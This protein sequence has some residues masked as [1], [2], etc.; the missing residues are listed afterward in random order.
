MIK[1]DLS[2]IDKA[3]KKARK[4]KLPDVSEYCFTPVPAPRM[5]RA[6]GWRTPKR[7]CVQR[8]FDFKDKVERAAVQ[9]PESGAHITF[10]MPMPPSWKGKKRIVHDGKPHQQKPDIDNLLKALLDAVYL[11]DSHIWNLQVT[12]LWGDAGKIVIKDLGVI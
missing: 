4:P 3:I 5:T 9:I 1:K 6:D 10:I 11:E 12:K 8:Y 7:P 2:I